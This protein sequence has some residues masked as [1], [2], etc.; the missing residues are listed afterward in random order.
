MK[1]AAVAGVAM[2]LGAITGRVDVVEEQD[3][4]EVGST[5]GR[6][7]WLKRFELNDDGTELVAVSFFLRLPAPPLE[8]VPNTAEGV[9]LLAAAF[10]PIPSVMLSLLHDCSGTGEGQTLALAGATGGGGDIRGPI[11]NL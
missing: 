3:D 1:G 4:D 2:T 8:L 10:C 11:L 9:V 5:F 7:G 6:I